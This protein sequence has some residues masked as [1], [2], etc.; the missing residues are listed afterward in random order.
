MIVPRAKILMPISLYH[1]ISRDTF[2]YESYGV[3]P[4]PLYEMPTLC[5]ERHCLS[6]AHGAAFS[7]TLMALIENAASSD[8]TCVL[9][10][11]PCLS[12][13][14]GQRRLDELRATIFLG[15][16]CF[17]EIYGRTRAMLPPTVALERY[18][19]PIH[20]LRYASAFTPRFDIY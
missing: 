8:A 11:L 16:A 19:R 4:A 20:R 2:D 6:L 7:H 15:R 3:L 9:T 13:A 18:A 10:V 14:F 1:L 17:G 5:F 12:E